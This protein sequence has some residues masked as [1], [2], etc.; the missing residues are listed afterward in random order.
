MQVVY[1]HSEVRQSSMERV[2]YCKHSFVAESQAQLSIF[3]RGFLFGDS[4]YEV[5]AVVNGR[6]VDNDLHLDRLQRSLVA[7]DVPMPLARTAMVAMQQQLI[8][9]NNMTEGLIYMQVSR[10]EAERGFTYE[11]G[12]E[13]TLIAFT[14]ERNLADTPKQRAGIAV[15]F[16][17]DLR[18]ARRDIKTTMLLSQVLAKQ[19]ALQEGYDDVWMTEDGVITEGGSST[20]FIIT[21]TGTLLTRPNSHAT[22][23]GCTRKAVLRLCDNHDLTL[24]ERA[25]TPAEAKQACEAFVTSASSFVTPVV[26]L[27]DTV[28]GDGQPGPMTRRLQAYYVAAA[29]GEESIAASS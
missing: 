28:I 3:D 8:L 18:W 9:R 24:E 13:P 29:R 21:P 23:P 1:A 22:L 6:M 25:F 7:I 14:Q 17:A 11:A 26:R 20:A 5:T 15:K 12:L 16:V 27:D 10:G 2:V 19:Q 4:I